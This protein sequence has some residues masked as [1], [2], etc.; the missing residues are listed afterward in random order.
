MTIELAQALVEQGD[1]ADKILELYDTIGGL[2]H[3][4]DTLFGQTAG[5]A[6]HRQA[7]EN[8]PFKEYIFQKLVEQYGEAGMKF[9]DFCVAYEMGRREAH[10]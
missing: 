6:T 1:A 2:C 9:M 8:E 5:L 7:Y 3:V 4:I 10:S